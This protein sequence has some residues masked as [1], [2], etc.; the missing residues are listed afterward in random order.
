MRKTA[1]PGA[2]ARSRLFIGVACV[3]ALAP[4]V[5]VGAVVTGDLPQAVIAYGSLGAHYFDF[6]K[7]VEDGETDMARDMKA[8][9]S[10]LESLAARFRT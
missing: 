4:T 5:G 9:R 10:A 1:N 8:L 3:L 6:Y 2:S 7:I